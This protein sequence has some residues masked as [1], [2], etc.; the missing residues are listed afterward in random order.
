MEAATIILSE[1]FKH[2]IE[3][4]QITVTLWHPNN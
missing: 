2:G 3:S 1:A 4:S